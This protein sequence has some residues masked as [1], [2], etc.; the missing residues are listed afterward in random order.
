MTNL[1]P[2]KIKF[3]WEDKEQKISKEI[4]RVASHSNSLYYPDFNENFEINTDASNFHLE[5]VII[6]SQDTIQIDF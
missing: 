6:V 1:T 2:I 4:T 3:K 5:E